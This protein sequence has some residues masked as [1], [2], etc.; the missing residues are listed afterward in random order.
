MSKSIKNHTMLVVHEHTMLIRWPAVSLGLF[1]GFE[2]LVVCY[3]HVW[4][5]R[6][7]QVFHISLSVWYGQCRE[8]DTCIRI[9]ETYLIEKVDCCLYNLIQHHC[10]MT[11]HS[12]S[13]IANVR[14]S[15]IL[16]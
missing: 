14:L 9:S 13:K 12:Q 10:I 11:H 7:M 1:Q 5:S 6:S 15:F 8:F 2:L 4:Y 3:L 16:Y